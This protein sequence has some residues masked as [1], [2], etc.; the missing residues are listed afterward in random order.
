MIK[1]TKGDPKLFCT[2]EGVFTPEEWARLMIIEREERASIERLTKKAQDEETE[3]HKKWRLEYKRREQENYKIFKKCRRMEGD[4]TFNIAKACKND[5]QFDEVC[6]MLDM[7]SLEFSKKSHH[8][9]ERSK[10]KSLR[11][12]GF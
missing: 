6:Q 1:D 12:R 9:K 10:M 5:K 7:Y 4:I 8:L 3:S 2:K 11:R